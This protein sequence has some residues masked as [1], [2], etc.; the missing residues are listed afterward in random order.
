LYTSKLGNSYRGVWTALSNLSKIESLYFGFAV[1]TYNFRNLWISPDQ[2][3]IRRKFTYRA[4]WCELVYLI[5]NIGFLRKDA[6]NSYL[7]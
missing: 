3:E 7:N 6:G 1:Q 5:E 4:K 2:S